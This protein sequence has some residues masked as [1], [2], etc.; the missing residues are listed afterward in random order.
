M[1][2]LILLYGIPAG[3]FIILGIIVGIE[4][5]SSQEW[6]G[7]LIMFIVFSTIYVAIKKHR[8]QDLG[9]VIS[10]TKALLVGLGIASVAGVVYVFVWEIYSSFDNHAFI[11]TYTNS[12]IE[13][14]RASDKSP[15][16]IAE[17][18][19][20]LKAMGERYRNPLYRLPMTFLEIFPPGVLVSLGSALALRN[21][22]AAS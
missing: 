3:L 14:T 19:A 8:D 11:D 17:A 5:G 12:M 13:K 2:R 10:F 1:A 16:E 22:T 4:F 9:G 7:Y 15:A 20:D 6:L 18:I 21:H